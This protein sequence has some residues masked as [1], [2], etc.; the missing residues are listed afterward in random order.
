MQHILSTAQFTTKNLEEI[1][2]H[3][4]YMK[5]QSIRDPLALLDMHKGKVVA[6]LFYEP[7]TR[8]RLSFESAAQRIGASIISTENAAEF[9]SAIKGETIEDTVRVIEGYA[10]VIVMRHKENDATERAAA[11]SSV[12]IVS[13]GAGTEEHP[14]Q[15]LLD[16]YTIRSKLGRTDDLNIVIG[17]DL[18]HGRTARSLARLAALYKG[19]RITFVS[20]PELQIEKDILDYLDTCGIPHTETADLGASLPEADVIYWTRLQKERQIN[21]L[22]AS[23][24]SITPRELDL[25]SPHAIILHPLPRTDELHADIDAD[26]RAAYFEQAHNGLYVRMALLD[27]LLRQ[28]NRAAAPIQN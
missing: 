4:D 8:T 17:G 26:T 21:G 27:Q 15:A 10:D 11:V 5:K 18:K 3:A 6:T 14:T 22:S 9:S 16:L 13:G 20:T 12:P 19:N 2:D 25:M 23:N 28:P 1:F 24:I 7:S